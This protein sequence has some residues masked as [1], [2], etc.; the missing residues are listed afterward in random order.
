MENK[1]IGIALAII[2]VA[3]A[4]ILGCTPELIE[5]Q[6]LLDVWASGYSGN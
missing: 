5:Q 1:F 2:I 6:A 4:S 3:I